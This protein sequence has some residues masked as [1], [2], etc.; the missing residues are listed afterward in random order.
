MPISQIW[1]QAVQI[2]H[3]HF[4]CFGQETHLETFAKDGGIEFECRSTQVVLLALPLGDEV[5]ADL[6]ETE[7][8]TRLQLLDSVPCTTEYPV[9]MNE[10][11]TS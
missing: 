11:W 10:V 2:L 5:S 3:L 7:S 6:Q 4:C 8:I 9:K 1:L